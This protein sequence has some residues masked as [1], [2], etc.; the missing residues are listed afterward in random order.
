[1]F[2]FGNPWS[3]K[4]NGAITGGIVKI[5]WITPAIR[6]R[7]NS[8]ITKRT[9]LIRTVKSHQYRIK[10]PLPLPQQIMTRNTVKAFTVKP[11]QTAQ[12]TVSRTVSVRGV[13][14]ALATGR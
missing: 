11:E 12:S 1:M 5:D 13:S 8:P 6:I 9:Q 2:W 10:S 7:I 4:L 14:H 3:K